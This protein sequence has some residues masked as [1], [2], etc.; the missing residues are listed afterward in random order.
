MSVHGV[1]PKGSATMLGSTKTAQNRIIAGT[2]LA[3]DWFC[4]KQS[5]PYLTGTAR[6]NVV[7]EQ[8]RRT[9]QASTAERCT[10]LVPDFPLSRLHCGLLYYHEEVF[11]QAV[12]EAADSVYM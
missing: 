11:Q 6:S 8:G 12:P 7:G 5:T 10:S 4:L 9:H 3:C 2:A 1:V